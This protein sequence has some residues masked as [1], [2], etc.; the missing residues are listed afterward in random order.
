M[1]PISSLSRLL[2]RGGESQSTARAVA[3][4]GVRGSATA[5]AGQM[6]VHPWAA[7]IADT[8]N[9]VLTGRGG[10]LPCQ[11]C[12]SEHDGM[13]NPRPQAEVLVFRLSAGAGRLVFSIGDDQCTCTFVVVTQELE[14]LSLAALIAFPLHLF[15]FCPYQGFL[16]KMTF[17][18][19]FLLLV[20]AGSIPM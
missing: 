19:L 5:G 13:P 10:E 16:Q 18:C 20:R 8:R 2:A 3:G 9:C 15:L 6:Q 17:L 7:L 12:C 4:P 11:R 14:L 1:V